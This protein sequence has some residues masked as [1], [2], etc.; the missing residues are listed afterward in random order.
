MFGDLATLSHSIF[1][2][3][4]HYGTNLFADA[5]LVYNTAG[6]LRNSALQLRVV[7]FR[8]FDFMGKW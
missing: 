6:L 8:G 5:F 2:S 1:D 4:V 3:N 7:C